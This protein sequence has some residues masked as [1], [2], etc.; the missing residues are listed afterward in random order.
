MFKIKIILLFLLVPIFI[1]CAMVFWKAKEKQDYNQRVVLAQEI[2]GAMNHLMFD[3]RSARQ[4]SV[5]EVLADG[6][7]HDRIAFAD[8][9]GPVEYFLKDGHLDRRSAGKTMSIA[10]H[11]AFLHMRRPSADPAVLEVQIQAR[12]RLSLTSNFKIRMQE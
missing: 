5:Q 9:H 10:D 12:D 2:H 3:L 11:I 6:Q 1:L 7:W 8:A 4:G